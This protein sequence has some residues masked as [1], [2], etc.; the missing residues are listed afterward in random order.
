MHDLSTLR[1]FGSQKHLGTESGA[2]F[3]P[4]KWILRSRLF[5]LPLER[6]ASE[7]NLG[8]QTPIIKGAIRIMK[9][10]RLI[11]RSFT[12]SL[13]RQTEFALFVLLRAGQRRCEVFSRQASFECLPKHKL[14]KCSQTTEK[15]F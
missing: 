7:E 1:A 6:K 14:T 9:I 2:L 8:N 4:Q 3:F 15:Q 5:V 11:A 13:V 12:T 10:I